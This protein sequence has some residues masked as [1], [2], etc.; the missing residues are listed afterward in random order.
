MRKEFSKKLVSGTVPSAP[1]CLECGDTIKYG[2]AD[3]KFCCDACKNKYH[4]RQA[5]DSRQFRQMVHACLERNYIILDSLRKTN[6]K[7]IRM[8]DLE[9]M[10]FKRDFFTSYYRSLRHEVYMCYDL[11]Y[12]VSGETVT[13]ISRIRNVDDV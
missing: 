4:N 7:N 3:R 9:S 10:G 5:Q 1:V 13:S 12:F 11:R 8:A 6:L 2:R